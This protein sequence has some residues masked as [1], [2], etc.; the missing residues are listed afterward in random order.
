MSAPHSALD[1]LLYLYSSASSLE[2]VSEE[3]GG[4]HGDEP[5]LEQCI[6]MLASFVALIRSEID[7]H[8]WRSNYS[9]GHP[10]HVERKHRRIEPGVDGKPDRLVW[11]PHV[12]TCKPDGTV[13]G[14]PDEPA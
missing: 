11:V 9:T 5:D 1:S 6:D 2:W 14:D 10:V 8:G 4:V 12:H 7:V 13:I 3:L